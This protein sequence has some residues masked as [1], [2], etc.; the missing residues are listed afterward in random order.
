M[1]IGE[2]IE[3]NLAYRAVA[4]NDINLFRKALL[5]N[6]YGSIH[7]INPDENNSTTLIL[8]SKL[9]RSDFVLELLRIGCDVEAKDS[10]G[11]TA[12][13]YSVLNNHKNIFDYLIE[14][15]ADIAILNNEN[16]TLLHSA[17]ICGNLEITKTLME[18]K[19]IDHNKCDI[20]GMTAFLYSCKNG[21]INVMKY[22][23]SKKVNTDLSTNNL[24][25]GLY[26]SSENKHFECSNYIIENISGSLT[27][28][29][30]N[31]KKEAS[32]F[33]VN[34]AVERSNEFSAISR[35]FIDSIIEA[36][37]LDLA[38]TL[39]VANIQ[40]DQPDIRNTD[41]IFIELCSKKHLEVDNLVSQNAKCLFLSS[42]I[43][44]YCQSPVKVLNKLYDESNGDSE[45]YKLIKE[46]FSSQ[47][48][49]ALLHLLCYQKSL[50]NAARAH[51]LEQEDF[52]IWI[53][54]I[55]A[56]LLEIFKTKSLDNTDHLLQLLL[57]TLNLSKYDK[58]EQKIQSN[59]KKLSSMDID[60]KRETALG[61]E[62]KMDSVKDSIENMVDELRKEQDDFMKLHKS[63]SL[64]HFEKISVLSYC[65]S[66]DL[67]LLFQCSQVSG[68]IESVFYSAL[69]PNK[70]SLEYAEKYSICHFS[71]SMIR[72][73]ERRKSAFLFIGKI[74][75]YSSLIYP[76]LLDTITSSEEFEIINAISIIENLRYC[77]VAMFTAE[78]VSKLVMIGLVAYI[79]LHCKTTADIC[80]ASEPEV[81]II[82]MVCANII[83]EVGKLNL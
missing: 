6:K 74:L 70:I 80:E 46:F 59:I 34:M 1:R 12:I 24:K 54:Q 56:L 28:F 78:L 9:G 13:Y 11:N 32:D 48:K 61:L 5:E 3:N 7:Y 38:V 42:V 47:D 37:R 15:E 49:F 23:I 18:K 22:L 41:G 36:G 64:A 45:I 50:V 69:I 72:N 30:K 27:K 14:H 43:L 60:H 8:A 62:S 68:I 16:R 51:P 29:L 73:N 55:D 66:K 77:P 76:E 17:A 82:F 2:E 25:S 63:W 31:F 81:Y 67:K 71:L 53:S 58:L 19:K 44:C 75:N 35:Y 52:D 65:V 10:Y 39:L 83:Y 4:D 33:V 79:S 26:F 21:H 20:E 57:P 40:L